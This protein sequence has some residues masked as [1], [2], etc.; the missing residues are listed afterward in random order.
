MKIPVDRLDEAITFANERL[1]PKVRECDGSLG[2]SMAVNR[3]NGSSIMVSSW[4][5]YEAM[6]ASEP[7]VDGLRAEAAALFGDDPLVGEWEIAAMHRER[8]S[9]P[10]SY[11]MITWLKVDHGDIEAVL[12]LYLHWA[13]PKVTELPGFQS[14]SL[15][16]M[17]EHGN[18]VG[19]VSFVDKASA[20]LARA[21]INEIRREGVMAA[22]GYF[23]DLEDY[24]LVIAHLDVPEYAR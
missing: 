10:D 8:P 2:M 18:F 17:P 14:S 11:L 16:V 21:G 22:K 24:D 12:D 4:K 15:M 9:S 6:V 13:L 3:D 5:T 23:L 7:T 19:A 1:L 20:E